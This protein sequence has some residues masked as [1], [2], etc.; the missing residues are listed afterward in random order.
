[1]DRRTRQLRRRRRLAAS[2]AAAMIALA[3]VLPLTLI[4]GGSSTTIKTITPV[5]TVPAITTPP[6]TLTTSTI[7]STTTPATTT[8]S[9][10]STTAL[11]SP[12]SVATQHLPPIDVAGL[13]A[14]VG[15]TCPSGLVFLAPANQASGQCL[16]PDFLGSNADSA[17]PAGSFMTMGPVEC[18]NDTGIVAYVPPGPNTCSDPGGPCPSANLPLPRQVSVIP[19]SKVVLPTGRCPAGYFFGEASGTA[20]CVPYGYLP[21]GTASAPNG[22]TACPT[23]SG[24]TQKETGTLCVDDTSRNIVA[25]IRPPT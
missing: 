7:E 23:G 14:P 21:G 15:Y 18:T 2:A 10:P 4:S 13:P 24:L 25:P 5:S 12:T 22:N 11:P 20:T 6:T 1:V 9:V 16:P 17:C 19:W 8:T 3:V